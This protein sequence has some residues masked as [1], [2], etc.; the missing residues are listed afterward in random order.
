MQVDWAPIRE[1]GAASIAAGKPVRPT[2][3]IVV[4]WD[5]SELE[6]PVQMLVK[7]T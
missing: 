4:R 7:V 3:K 2:G 5:E 1:R 6:I